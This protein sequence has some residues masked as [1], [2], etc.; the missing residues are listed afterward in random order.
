MGH[1]HQRTKSPRAAAVV[2]SDVDGQL[3]LRVS[4]VAEF[5]PGPADFKQAPTTL[6]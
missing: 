2:L 6:W 1:H 3:R 4:E 5:P